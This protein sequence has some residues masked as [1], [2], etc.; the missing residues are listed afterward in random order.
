MASKEFADTANQEAAW[1]QLEAQLNSSF[2]TV[3]SSVER[4]IAERKAQ[5]SKVVAEAKTEAL[6]ALDRQGLLCEL[7][8]CT[9]L[10]HATHRAQVSQPLMLML[11]DMGITVQ[12]TVQQLV[13]THMMQHALSMMLISMFCFNDERCICISVFSG[14]DTTPHRF[15]ATA[16]LLGTCPELS[17]TVN[18]MVGPCMTI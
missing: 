18:S 4:Q 5:Y 10:N 1:Q 12:C 15:A 14:A 7:Q 3:L 6:K 17:K 11:P 2:T 9:D 13:D 8:D 16:G